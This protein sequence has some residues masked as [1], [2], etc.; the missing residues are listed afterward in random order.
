MCD[1]Q[2]IMKVQIID[3]FLIKAYNYVSIIMRKK[4]CNH[5]SFYNENFNFNVMED[6]EVKEYLLDKIDPL[7]NLKR[8]L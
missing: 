2:E 5:I 7:R 8:I 1:L 4:N 6:N 3:N